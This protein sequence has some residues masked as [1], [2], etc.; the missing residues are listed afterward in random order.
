MIIAA[1]T[2]H[3]RW[4]TRTMLPDGADPEFGY[5][6][7]ALAGGVG[8]LVW[9]VAAD[10]FP[11]RRLLIILAVLSLPAAGWGWLLD[12]PEGGVLL[13]SL[14]GGGLVSLPWVL[15]AE[16]LPGRHFAKLALGLT[17]VGLLGRMLG[18]LYWGSA[19]AVWGVDSFFWIVLVEAGLLA[20]V[21]ACR[22]RLPETFGNQP[23]Q[24]P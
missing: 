10:F 11:V 15:M 4:V 6:A 5:R 18:P 17:W 22:P 3:L 24:Q 1:E 20:A 8:A 13:L 7:L 14:V 2:T 16:L 19:L 9:G 12:D 21:V 23:I